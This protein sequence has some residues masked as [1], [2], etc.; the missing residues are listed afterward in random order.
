MIGEFVQDSMNSYYIESGFLKDQF[1]GYDQR[2][3]LGAGLYKVIIKEENMNLRAAAGIEIT[4]EEF[5]D[6]TSKTNEWIKFGLKGDKMMQENM[7]LYSFIDFG[8]PSG[9]YDSRY[10]VDMGIGTIFTVN[11][12][13]DLEA[14]YLTNYRKTPLV[15]GKEKTDSTFITNLVY[16]M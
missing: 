15:D 12:Q 9:D 8:A 10:E 4:K 7:K 11:S 3:N 2:L 1:A 6:S 5:T 13:F 14:K 16:K